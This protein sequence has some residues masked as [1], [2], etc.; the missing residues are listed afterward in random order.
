MA[1]TTGHAVPTTSVLS[2]LRVAI[3]HDYL[4]QQGGA[5]RVAEVFS[6]MF[7]GAPIFTSIY[8]PD[9][10]DPYWRTVDVRT[11][12]LQRLGP[13]PQACK[14]FATAVPPGI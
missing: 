4:N 1:Y 11:S 6:R 3:V 7:P 13:R 9:S 8:R 2:S 10:V 5:E 12:F 14:G